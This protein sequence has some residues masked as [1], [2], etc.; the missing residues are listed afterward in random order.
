ME[1]RPMSKPVAFAILVLGTLSALSLMGMLVAPVRL[2]SPLSAV[3]VLSIGLVLTL[4]CI[5]SIYAGTFS[6]GR[7]GV[8]QDEISRQNRPIGFWFVVLFF[9]IFSAVMILLGTS[10]LWLFFES[11]ATGA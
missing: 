7:P 3:A 4:K 10:L 6:Y 8:W 9:A 2:R 5:V 11:H 1:R